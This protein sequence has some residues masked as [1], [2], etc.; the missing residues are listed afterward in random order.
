MIKVLSEMAELR[1]I[2]LTPDSGKILEDLVAEMVLEDIRNNIDPHQYGN[3]KGCSTSHYLIYLLDNI[4][5]G[6]EANNKIA[7]IV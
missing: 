3:L 6:L 4:L 7:S 2:S 5:R 1:P